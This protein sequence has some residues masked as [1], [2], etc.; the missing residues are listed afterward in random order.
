MLEQK[1]KLK[2]WFANLIRKFREE[3]EKLDESEKLQ[4][5]KVSDYRHPCQIEVF[6]MDKPLERSI[7]VTS[8]DIDRKDMEIII[9][10]PYKG[11]EF[12]RE[13]EKIMQEPRWVKQVS[14]TDKAK[15]SDNFVNALSNFLEGV[16]NSV[17]LEINEGNQGGRMLA[18]DIWFWDVYGSV[19]HIDYNK[20]VNEAINE[21][22]SIAKKVKEKAQEKQQIIPTTSK[23]KGYGTF[24]YPPVWIGDIPERTF[25]QK[26]NRMQF[27]F[28]S[29]LFD[30]TFNGM[31][32]IVN[33]DGFIG[34]ENESKEQATE[35]LNTIF[36]MSVLYDET[37]FAVREHELA[38]INIDPN[39]LAITSTSI[40]ISSQRTRMLLEESFSSP[41][42]SH[43]R[44]NIV[45]DKIKE[46]I[47][48]T[49]KINTNK[50]LTEQ[51][52]FLL[53]GYTHF[54]NSEFS[55]SFIINWLIIEK[56]LFKLWEE[57][58]KE[59]RISGER[60]NKLLKNTNQ[61]GADVV[62]ETLNLNDKIDDNNYNLLNELKGKR[63]GFVHRRLFIDKPTSKILLDLCF[64]IVRNNV[65][66][67]LK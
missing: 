15:Y 28:P 5:S 58:I 53:E 56:Y 21:A 22:K 12:L 38:D 29:K 50:D 10:G 36:G 61:W 66:Q 8:H 45:E 42:M 1:E 30:L 4:I 65:S 46:I 11:Y 60:K 51:L 19:N 17:F 33:S 57:F 23:I 20:I 32:V 37:C 25:I 27:P 41:F 13:I 9:N 31:K 55:Q 63:N 16:R 2:E 7:I 39:S 3:Y 43:R 67:F 44:N 6:W 62:L 64:K 49:E 18:K 52:I 35:I 24:F 26:V 48:K 59:K 34:I 40:I 54:K 47:R 14:E